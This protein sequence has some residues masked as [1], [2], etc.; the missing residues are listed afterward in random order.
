MAMQIPT[1]SI[2]DLE[3]RLVP[4]RGVVPPGMLPFLFG[5]TPELASTLASLVATGQKTATGGLLWAWET[6][7]GRPPKAGQVYLVHDWEGTPIAVIENIQ[8]CIVPF[9]L[10]DAAF[11][12]EEGEGDRSLAWWRQAHWCYFSEECRR[13]GREPAEDMSIVCQRFRLLYPRAASPCGE[14]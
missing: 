3:S 12:W 1:F 2:Q 7:E 11:A 4:H 10:V 13:V 9:H 14:P 6:D 8:V 5:N